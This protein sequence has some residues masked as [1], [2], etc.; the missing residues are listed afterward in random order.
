[1]QVQPPAGVGHNYGSDLF[2]GL[3]THMPQGGQKWKKERKEKK[4]K[5]ITQ[6][7]MQDG[8]PPRLRW[9]GGGVGRI[10]SPWSRPHL[11]RHWAKLGPEESDYDNHSAAKPK[12]SSVSLVPWET[13]STSQGK[14]DLSRSSQPHAQSFPLDE[15]SPEPVPHMLSALEPRGPR[16]GSF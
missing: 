15:S 3:G 1:M 6:R 8:M 16:V 9:Q 11:R 7:E 5:E 13:H 14:G 2:P 10:S 4:R 12:V